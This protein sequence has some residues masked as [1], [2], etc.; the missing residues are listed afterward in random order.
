MN[1]GYDIVVVGGGHAGIEAAWAASRLGAST[2]LI[3]MDRRAIGRMSCNP[4]I[5]GIGKGHMVR[6]I[7]ALGG[8]MALATDRAGIQFRMLNRSKGPAVW[9]PR[10][11][12]DRDAYAAATQAILADADSLEIIEGVVDDLLTDEFNGRPRITGVRLADG[13]PLR[14]NAVILTTG[15]FLR[16]LMHC[17]SR[18]AEGGRIGEAP[19]VGVSR[20][21]ERLG[22][23]LGRLKTGT[24][25]RVH[26]DTLDYD[27]LEPQPGDDPPSPFSFM[28]DALPQRQ[29][30]CW[31]TYTNPDVHD[32]IRD[33]LHLA[34][35]YSGQIESRGPRYCPS[36]EDKVV[37]FAEK[38]RHQL[39]LE[40]E[41]YD[42]ERIYC[43]GIS[44]SLPAEVQD[45]M[46]RHVP[47]LE[48]AKILQHGYAVEY[49]W[50]P[51]HQTT[52]SLETKRVRGLYLAGQIN[53]TSGYE[54]AA[55]QGVLAGINAARAVGGLDPIVLGR[56]QAYLGVMIDDLLTKPQHEP[57]R[58]FTS[59][60][61]HRLRLRSDNADERLT[62][63]GR[64]IGLV[65][66]AR[67]RRFQTRQSAIDDVTAIV[68]S[69]RVDGAPLAHWL[70]RPDA[71]IEAFAGLL[72]RGLSRAANDN[73]PHGSSAPAPRMFDR[74]A[75]QEVLTRARY[76]GYLDRQTRHIERMR[77]L[78]HLRLP[79]ALDY[80]AV[81]HL[82]AEACENLARVR[83]A[84]LGQASRIPGITAADLTVLWLFVTRRWGGWDAGSPAAQTP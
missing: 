14:A 54:E 83:P 43:N 38:D 18:R 3:T 79:E 30:S 45:R 35:M 48:N 44:T 59:R 6:E 2:A 37:R 21:L 50:V 7:D 40:P 72:A 74:A 77:K 29:V 20:A 62:P 75:L 1:Q 8:L 47:G 42:N 70:R 10:A 36:I 55:G 16:G 26:R 33:N 31:I 71:T 32:L 78:E 64:E 67:W 49:D 28:T 58:M 15:T 81:G 12:C 39:F 46:I 84:T 60:A 68:R 66:D 69:L 51:S 5:G 22:F 17:G 9:A 25:P 41:G 80:A 52:F 13:R 4:A 61:E 19:A 76:E 63:L 73:A 82:K 56:D 65:D 11:Q 24:P 34:P 27:R 53:G 57:Y 23:E